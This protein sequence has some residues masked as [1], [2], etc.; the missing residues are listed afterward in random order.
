MQKLTSL[1]SPLK[2]SNGVEI[3]GLGFGTFQTP[4]DV[5]RQVVL[6]ALEVGYRHIDT[7][8]LYDNEMGVGQAVR[9]S[10]LKREDVF[11]TTKLWNTDR[12]YDETLKAFEVSLDRLG[13]DYVDLYLIHWPANRKQFGDKA[14]ELNAQTWRAFEDLYAQGRIKAIGVSN[15]LPNHLEDLAKTATI[16]PMVN[17]IEF[18][19]GWPQTETMQY[20]Q[21][22]DILV[23]AWAP[24]GEAASLTN[25]VIGEIAEKYQHTPAQICLRWEIQLGL[26]PLPKSVHRNRIEENTRIFDF[27][28]TDAEMDIIGSR[29]GLGGQCQIPDFVE[30]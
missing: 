18:H 12:G 8:F 3:P 22:N 21:R 5:T 23:E 4:P 9:E 2:L 27:E 24:L 17:Q 28:L 19:P 25:D 16:K 30:F 13:L 20:C 6:D 7:A 26:L 10:G 1:T 14:A 29:R 11:V 15:F